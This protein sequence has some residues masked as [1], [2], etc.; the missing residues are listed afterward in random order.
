[1]PDLD[2]IRDAVVLILQSKKGWMTVNEIR[3]RSRVAVDLESCLEALYSLVRQELAELEYFGEEPDL[4]HRWKA[5]NMLPTKD[6][7]N[8]S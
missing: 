8:G 6:A 7:D 2:E 3:S 1:M 5:I 4:E